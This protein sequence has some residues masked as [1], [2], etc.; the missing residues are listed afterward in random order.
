MLPSYEESW[1]ETLYTDYSRTLWTVAAL[2]VPLSASFCFFRSRRKKQVAP[3]KPQALIIVSSGEFEL[4]CVALAAKAFRAA[5]L[6]VVLCN[7]EGGASQPDKFSMQSAVA[8]EAEANKDEAWL[9]VLK[10]ASEKMPALFQLR[11]D[12]FVAV[13]IAGGPRALKDLR[14]TTLH[15]KSPTFF[16]EDLQD[17]CSRVLKRGGV[18]GATGHGVHGLPPTPKDGQA[19][20]IFRGEFDSRVTQVVGDMAD[21]LPDEVRPPPAIEAAAPEAAAAAPEAAAAAPE[22]VPAPESADAAQ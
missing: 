7:A 2:L 11:P 14:E 17:F 18:V 15:G 13:F 3:D 12:H 19:E 21:A 22:A 16:C 4:P 8:K 1:L 6:G 10:S 9:T 20:R 5:N